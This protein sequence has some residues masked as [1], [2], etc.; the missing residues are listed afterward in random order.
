VTDPT[1]EIKK[2]ALSTLRWQWQK[3]MGVFVIIHLAMTLPQALLPH[4]AFIPTPWVAASGVPETLW[5]PL[6]PDLQLIFI[7]L[8][9]G[10]IAL[11]FANLSLLIVRGREYGYEASFYGFGNILRAV[12]VWLL[13]L[14]LVSMGAL[15]LI[16]PG[17]VLAFVYSMVFYILADDPSIGVIRA[18]RTSRAMMRGN[19]VNLL[20]VKFSF[21]GWALLLGLINISIDGL[22]GMFIPE[23]YRTVADVLSVLLTCPFAAMF[24]MYFNAAHAVFYEMA[25]GTRRIGFVADK[26]MMGQG[27]G[28]YGGYGGPYG[29]YGGGPGQ[30]FGGQGGPYSGPE[31]PYGQGQPP[32]GQGQP[33]GPYGGE[34]GQP[35][36]GQGV[37]HSG[38]EQP[39]DMPEGR[40][41][42]GGGQPDNAPKGQPQPPDDER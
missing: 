1:S 38:P 29:P 19:K 17:I 14:L 37:P 35:Y 26:Y 3:A 40:P 20:A 8:A 34:P 31:A 6:A 4:I 23:N 39:Q 15:L 2:L 33:Y 32:G 21:I 30:P 11:S 24:Y 10:P 22:I 28:P 9:G 18:L 5:E 16:F 7:L 36:N 27:P 41:Y 25:L 13:M 12:G 42:G